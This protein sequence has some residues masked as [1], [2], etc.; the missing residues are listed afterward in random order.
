MLIEQLVRQ[1]IIETREAGV[2]LPASS[3]GISFNG[4]SFSL[5]NLSG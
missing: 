4:C 5:M 1:R 3:Q 2:S